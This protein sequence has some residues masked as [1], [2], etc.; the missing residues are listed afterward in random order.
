MSASG[1]GGRRFPG[2]EGGPPNGAS[3]NRPPGGGFAGAGSFATGKV[4]AVTGTSLTISGFSSA[5]FTRP[6]GKSRRR[7]R[8]PR[9]DPRRRPSK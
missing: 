4:T 1:N 2:G 7:R 9:N 5:S 8:Q 6:S 3:G